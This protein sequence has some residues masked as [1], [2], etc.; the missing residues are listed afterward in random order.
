[1]FA[2]SVSVRT[3]P[4]SL[5]TAGPPESPRGRAKV[6][7]FWLERD[8]HINPPGVSRAEQRDRM[9]LHPGAQAQTQVL[10]PQVRSPCRASWPGPLGLARRPG[11]Q[12]AR[13]P[14]LWCQLGW[15]EGSAKTS[16][17]AARPPHPPVASLPVSPPGRLRASSGRWGLTGTGLTAAE[18]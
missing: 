8:P 1:M 14:A 11:G 5:P 3:G 10:Q 4:V 7:A 16:L 2:P 15:E 17:Q 6:L 9:H 12:S 18:V 13:A